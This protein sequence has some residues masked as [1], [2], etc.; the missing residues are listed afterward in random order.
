[1]KVSAIAAVAALAAVAVAGPVRPSGDKYLIE[2]GPGK[3][4]WVT[5]DQK[6]KMRA[7]RCPIVLITENRKLFLLTYPGWTNLH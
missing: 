7:V 6:H 2:L 4:Q 3:T 5:K 1:M